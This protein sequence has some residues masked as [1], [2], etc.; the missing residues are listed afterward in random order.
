MVSCCERGTRPV[1]KAKRIPKL[2][3]T[4]KKRKKRCVKLIEEDDYEVEAAGD[5]KFRYETT[6]NDENEVDITNSDIAPE[7]K[8]PSTTGRHIRPCICDLTKSAKRRIVDFKKAKNISIKKFV[9]RKA[10]IAEEIARME[11]EAKERER[12]KAEE[13]EFYG[14]EYAM[15]GGKKK[16]KQRSARRASMVSLGVRQ[17]ITWKKEPKIKVIMNRTWHLRHDSAA[18]CCQI[19]YLLTMIE[20]IDYKKQPLVPIRLTHAYKLRYEVNNFLKDLLINEED[21]RPPFTLE[22]IT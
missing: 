3:I 8:T 13:K 10:E 20:N 22:F 9:K 7:P 18:Y 5:D 12:E 16:R 2:K 1:T 6:S 11:E 14:D 17:R 19:K 15:V 21:K 4:S